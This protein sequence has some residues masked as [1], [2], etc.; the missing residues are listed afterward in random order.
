MT[1]PTETPL[2]WEADASASAP[3]TPAPSALRGLVVKL[4]TLR[5]EAAARDAQIKAKV[6]ELTKE[7]A[8]EKATLEGL[9]RAIE[10]S[11]SEVRALAQLERERTGNKNPCPG[12]GVQDS[13]TYSVT[14][15]A[16]AL[17]WAKLSSI[18]YVPET[19]DEDAIVQAV[20]KGGATLP[21]VKKTPGYKVKLATDLLKALDSAEG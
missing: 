8:P 10:A 16:A 7:L 4:A 18:G 9:K 20:A 14:D 21:F 12:V 17:A 13:P 5:A 19:I 11:E 15:R 1:A 2:P 6:A 3:E